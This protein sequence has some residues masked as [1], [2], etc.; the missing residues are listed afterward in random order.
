MTYKVYHIRDGDA[1]ITLYLHQ[2]YRRKVI[3]G[4]IK[5]DIGRILRMLCEQKGMEIIE[6]EACVDHIYMLVSIPPSI[7]IAAFIGYLKGKSTLMIFDRHA[8]LWYKYG[9][10]HFRCRGYYV[11]TVRKNETMIREYVRNQLREDI[12]EDQL[13]FK[14]YIDPFTGAKNKKA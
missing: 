11:D 6:A 8:N 1:N 9:S 12:V 13:T 4:R 5:T 7:N 10:R 3:Y 2:K 14:E